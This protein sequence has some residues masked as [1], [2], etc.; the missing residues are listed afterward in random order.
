M[1]MSK[2]ATFLFCMS[3][4]AALLFC[5]CR[6]DRYYQSLAADKARAYLLENAPELTPQQMAFVKYNDPVLLTGDGLSGRASGIRQ[7]CVAWEIPGADRLY[8][9]YGASRERMDD[10]SPKQLIK[11]NYVKPAAGID[12]AISVVRTA[13]VSSMRENLSKEDLNIIRFS[14][15][16]IAV[17]SFEL[18]PENSINNPND[19]TLNKFDKVN[20]GNSAVARDN[21]L[22]KKDSVQISLL[23]K[24]SDHRFVVFCGTSSD[25]S[26]NNWKM[27][28]AGIIGDYETNMACKKFL[29]KSNDYNTPVPVSAKGEK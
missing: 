14:N 18:R 6:S 2:I 26:L 22:N 13:A 5:G 3:A 29:K 17:T 20:S 11:R 8:M 15:P 21:A 9:V 28:F 7:I 16:E 10:W 25:E 19:M 4:A 12:T 23:W 27:N 24:I 1:K